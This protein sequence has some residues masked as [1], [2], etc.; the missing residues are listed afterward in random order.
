MYEANTYERILSNLL[1]NAPPDVDTRPGSVIYD[2]A[3]SCAYELA[4]FYVDLD[5]FRALTL[6]STAVDEYLDSLGEEF[7]VT[8]NPATTAR[9]EF[10][11]TGTRPAAGE[12]FFANGLY[13]ALVETDG[14]LRLVAEEPGIASN[15]IITGTAAVPVNTI[16]GL[17][18]ASFGVLIEPGVDTEDD[19]S[20]RARI[21]QKIAGPASNGN[22]QHYKTWCEEVAGVGQARIIPCFAG[23]NTVL[24]VLIGADGLPAAATVVSRVQEYIDPIELNHT[25]LLDGKTIPIGDGLGKGC[26][27]IGA[28]FAAL[29]ATSVPISVSCNVELAEGASVADA[30]VEAQTA[31]TEHLKELALSSSDGEDVVVRVSAILTLLYSQTTIIDCSNL[32][33]NGGTANLPIK[34]T[35]VA[36]LGEVTLSASV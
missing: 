24:A 20:Y 35:E 7:A 6:I 13:F 14:I 28:Q 15:S 17:D 8:R 23:Q 9:Y 36:T 18:A 21:Q 1:A 16:S 3:S 2:A 22:I 26:A 27:N 31:L 4:K 32:K 5:N 11:Y 29:A 34:R 30:K 19:D 12:R 10:T 25:A 33:I